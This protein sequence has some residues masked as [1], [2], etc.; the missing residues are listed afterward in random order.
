[1]TRAFHQST[2]RENAR[3]YAE[4]AVITVTLV[5]RT[6]KAVLVSMADKPEVW[7]PLQA[8]DAGGRLAV[9]RAALKD[10]IKI[11]VEL[12]LALA[13]SLV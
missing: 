8:L 4:Y 1:M 9:H 6:D 12:K 7:V 13:K 11:G 3:T 2:G 5:Q 10:E